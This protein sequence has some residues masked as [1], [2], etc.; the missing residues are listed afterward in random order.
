MAAV[1]ETIDTVEAL[2]AYE[3]GFVTDIETEYAP[4]GLTED[5]IRYISAKKEEPQ[6]ML[7]WRLAA[8]ERWLAMEE[9]DWAALMRK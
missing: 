9:P 6:W 1:K 2:E 4:K 3:H 8:F 5:T 7:G